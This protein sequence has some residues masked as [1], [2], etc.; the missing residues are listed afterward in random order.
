MAAPCNCFGC[1]IGGLL[2]TE[3]DRPDHD[4]ETIITI[5]VT[6]VARLTEMNVICVRPDKLPELA[7][8]LSQMEPETHVVH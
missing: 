4:R 1:Q 2:Q 6:A 8:F 3:L 5:L 7:T